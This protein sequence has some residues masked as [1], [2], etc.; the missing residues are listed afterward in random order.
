MIVSAAS[1]PVIQTSNKIMIENFCTYQILPKPPG[2]YQ[3][4]WNSQ[5]TAMD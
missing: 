1:G 2:K 3:E 5:L 4:V